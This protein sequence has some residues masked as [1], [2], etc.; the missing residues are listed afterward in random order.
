MEQPSFLFH[1]YETFGA[2][3]RRDRPS[4]FA[5]IRTDEA[6]NEIGEPQVIY[7]RQADDYLPHPQ[8]CLLTGIT[9]QL[10]SRRGIPEAEF[11]G[12][13]HEMMC[14]S[15]TC[16]LGYNTLRF[17]DEV[18]RHLFYRNFLDPYGREWQNGNSRWDLIDAV[19]TF[20]ALRPD[21]I[22]W[23]L[24]D[25]DQKPGVPSFKLEHLT[26]ANG[27]EHAGAHDALSDVRATIAM[28]R[29]LRAKNTKLFDYLLSL[30]DKHVVLGLLDIAARKPMLHISRRYPAARG[31]SA[32]I[33]PLAKHP[34]NPNGIIVYDLSVDPTPLFELDAEAIRAR[35]F[36]STDEL[37][38]GET[39]IPLKILHINRSPVLL[40]IKAVDERAAERLS[41]D[42]AQAERHWQMLAARSDVAVKAAE[43]FATEPPAGVADPDMMLY[44]GGFFSSAD[45][46]AMAEVRQAEPDALAELRPAFQD[47]RLED[48][49]FRYRARSYPDTLSSEER[50]QWDEYRWERINSSQTSSLTLQ[51][52][53]REI[54][55]LNQVALDDRQRQILEELVMYV[56]AMMPAQAFE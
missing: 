10:A 47:S 7:C 28:A 31:C 42:R 19:R 32:L 15:N 26:A 44:S 55:R 18:S 43:A 8:A 41:L 38:E 51:G 3:P 12:A 49:L 45:K 25:G 35:V 33:V 40:P 30:R 37:S 11:A 24:R 17:D 21:G 53:A 54:E 1:D 23:P 50:H 4:Q 13:I 52:F 14:V 29:L 56:E 34:K 16:S 20:Y 27:I 22:E 36:A 2:D 5:A 39:R 6:F 9:P 46:R 48:M